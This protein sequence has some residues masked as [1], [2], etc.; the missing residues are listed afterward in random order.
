MKTTSFTNEQIIRSVEAA[1][2]EV[3]KR[4]IYP[5]DQ[6]ED[7]GILLDYAGL[8]GHVSLPTPEEFSEGKPNHLAW[9]APTENGS[10]FNGL[11]LDALLYRAIQTG[12][13]KHEAKA[14]RVA[15][16]LIRMAEVADTPGFVA[17]GIAAD[18]KSHHAV[19]SDDQTAPWFYG[20]WRYVNS[21]LC[22]QSERERIIALMVE[23][24]DAIER[25]QWRMPCDKEGFIFRGSWQEGDFVHAARVMFMLK[26][27]SI[28]TD[29]PKWKRLY[30]E[31][32]NERPEGS[33][34]SRFEWCANGIYDE[35][36]TRY[37][38]ESQIEAASSGEPAA[39]P[40]PRKFPYWISASS[41]SCL[42]ELV[43]IEE[44]EALKEG[45]RSGLL[46]NAKRALAY[47]NDDRFIEY[48]NDNDVPFE[49]NWRFMNELWTPQHNVQETLD[50]AMQQ[51]AQWRLK[52]PRKQY[53][54]LRMREPLF[55]A[56]FITLSED[57]SLIHEAAPRIRQ[58]LMQYEWSKLYYS[59]FFIA[60]NVYYEGIRHG[61]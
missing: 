18:G 16:G 3:W 32:G 39:P 19:G 47:I 25:L 38:I 13:P 52:S 5:K 48:D 24:G 14:R 56:W 35:P 2:E 15:Y 4:F 6:H 1:H 22:N 43:V 36:E 46:A 41:Q 60:E 30:M 33:D 8:D 58:L 54:D 40:R 55:A 50:L 53:E 27:L 57:Q 42:R 44:D 31:V 29:D 20:L 9:W 21:K 59:L 37:E 7:Y 23:A 12:D 28:L 11:Y 61:L 51:F 17:R 45:Y 34:R 10:F 26:I 49:T